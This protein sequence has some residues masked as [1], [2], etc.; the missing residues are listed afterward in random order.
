MKKMI[1]LFA[2]LFAHQSFALGGIGN[3]GVGNLAGFNL[4][5]KSSVKKLKQR[6]KV[7]KTEKRKIAS[8]QRVQDIWNLDQEENGFWN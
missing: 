1:L 7:E 6:R 2:L 4:V 8:K 3:L 5:K